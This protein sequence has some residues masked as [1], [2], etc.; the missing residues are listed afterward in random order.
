MNL[1]FLDKLFLDFTLGFSVRLGQMLM[2]MLH[3]L[4]LQS[5]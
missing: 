1:A 2:K 3:C 4:G 5:L